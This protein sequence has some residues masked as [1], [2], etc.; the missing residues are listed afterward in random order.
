MSELDDEGRKWRG[1]RVNDSAP[2]TTINNFVR[3]H[4]Y[5][6]SHLCPCFRF[7]PIS[8]VTRRQGGVGGRVGESEMRSIEGWV[9]K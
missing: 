7:H 6:P 5:D 9:I 4:P 2:Q 3:A 8:S 1:G